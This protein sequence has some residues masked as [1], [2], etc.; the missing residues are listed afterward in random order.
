MPLYQHVILGVVVGVALWLAGRW[1]LRQAAGAIFRGA[2]RNMPRAQPSL[3]V[4]RLRDLVFNDP[5]TCMNLLWSEGRDAFVRGLWHEAGWKVPRGRARVALPGGVPGEVPAEQ[6]DL[7]A[8]GM[9]VHRL[10]L[11]DGRAIAVITAPPPQRK[12]EPLLIGVVLPSDPRLKDDLTL[13]RRSAHF[14]VLNEGGVGN[15]GRDTDLCGWTLDKKHLTYNVGAPRDV[16]GFAR[17]VDAK[18]QELHR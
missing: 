14:F 7:P 15:S 5:F 10:H 4:I 9:S 2:M 17:A 3:F 12:Y 16:E 6:S 8:D 1:A 13:A 11:L 18:L